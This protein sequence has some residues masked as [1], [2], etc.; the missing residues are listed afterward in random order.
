[1]R[2]QKD[3]KETPKRLQRGSK[4]APKRLQRDSKETPKRLRWHS[5]GTPKTLQRFKYLIKSLP[6]Y[7]IVVGQNLVVSLLDGLL[8]HV[9]RHVVLKIMKAW[10]YDL[11]V[12]DIVVNSGKYLPI[13][14]SDMSA[15][16]LTCWAKTRSPEG[17]FLNLVSGL[18]I[19]HTI[20]PPDPL[21]LYSENS[22]GMIDSSLLSKMCPM[23]DCWIITRCI[24]L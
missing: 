21:L 11:L 2:L 24:D 6:V 23:Q 7:A 12:Q 16:R 15:H 9:G 3:S 18:N 8:V 17:S 19:Y 20:V 13:L 5:D 1:M 10:I 4:E 14:M 22:L